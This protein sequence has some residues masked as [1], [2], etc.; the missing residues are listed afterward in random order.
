MQGFESELEQTSSSRL[1][2]WQHQVRTHS[3]SF[4]QLQQFEDCECFMRILK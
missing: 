1:E 2:R 4:E 3:Q